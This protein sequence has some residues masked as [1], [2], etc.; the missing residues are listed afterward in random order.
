[1]N[2]SISCNRFSR[3]TFGPTPAELLMVSM[4]EEVFYQYTCTCLRG[5]KPVFKY[6]TRHS[7]LRFS[8]LLRQ[9]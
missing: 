2:P 4:V 8:Q 9:P 3:I 7:H 6:V 5:L 1:M